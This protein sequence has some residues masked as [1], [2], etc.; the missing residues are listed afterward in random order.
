MQLSASAIIAWNKLSEAVYQ[1]NL[2]LV[3]LQDIVLLVKEL[4]TYWPPGYFDEI[5]EQ[6]L[7]DLQ[8]IP[9]VVVQQAAPSARL[10]LT[11][12]TVIYQISVRQD[13]PDEPATVT[14]YIQGR[15]SMQL[16][17]ARHIGEIHDIIK[18]LKAVTP[19]DH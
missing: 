15:E 9:D 3:K 4:R 14:W 12:G 5:T 1:D 2:R 11:V 16:Q 18:E 6:T 19:K 17:H 7:R 8:H 10:T 13:F